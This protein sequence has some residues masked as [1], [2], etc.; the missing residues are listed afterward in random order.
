MNNEPLE[1]M[2]LSDFINRAGD[3]L[4]VPRELRESIFKIESGWEH[5][6]R[7]GQVK[8]SPKGALGVGQLM[9]DTA[10]R[11]GVDPNDPV[12]N[13]Y[14]ALKEQKRLYEKY[15]EAT[16]NTKKAILLA[17][18]AYNAGEGAVDKFGGVPPYEETQNY[19][20][21]VAQSLRGVKSLPSQGYSGT[22]RAFAPATPD[23]QAQIRAG[24]DAANG[25]PS[26]RDFA[27]LTP[28]P[29]QVGAKAGPKRP[30]PWS[31][32]NL[33]TALP[34][35]LERLPA[36]VSTLA[37]SQVR[38]ILDTFGRGGAGIE[39]AVAGMLDFIDSSNASGFAPRL[40]PI[41]RA[42]QEQARTVK[43]LSAEA[44]QQR[45]YSAPTRVARDLGAGAVEFA[46]VMAAT[47]G[48]GAVPTAIAGGLYSGAASR[49]RGESGSEQ[50]KQT[51]LGTVAFGL[52]G[53]PTAS[54]PLQSALARAATK[55]G[56]VGAGTTAAN[57]AAG[58]SPE[59]ALIAGG[60]Q[61][62]L[63]SPEFLGSLKWFRHS[64]LGEVVASPDQA[65][66]PKGRVRVLD[67]QG[68]PHM[69]V[70][71]SRVTNQRAVP[72]R[73][74]EQTQ[75]FFDKQQAQ[76]QAKL[77]AARERLRAAE[78][79]DEYRAAKAEVQRLEGVFE[80]IA[81]QRPNARVP[82]IPVSTISQPRLVKP[83]STKPAPSEVIAPTEP[84]ITPT[85][86][87][88]I[89]PPPVEVSRHVP[90]V[91]TPA[92][93]LPSGREVIPETTLSAMVE[94]D[95]AL[96]V[97]GSKKHYIAEALAESSLRDQV[98]AAIPKGSVLTDANQQ[99]TIRLR[100]PDGSEWEVGLAYDHH[101]EVGWKTIGDKRDGFVVRQATAPPPLAEG[102]KQPSGTR[103]PPQVPLEQPS[104]VA[105]EGLSV[106]DEPRA[107]QL[108]RG[109]LSPDDVLDTPLAREAK[110]ILDEARTI[111]ETPT[112]PAVSDPQIPAP[113]DRQ[114]PSG[115]RPAAQIAGERQ[116][117]KSA[118]AAGLPEATDLTYDVVSDQAA[119]ERA[120]QRIA[121]STPD[122][123]ISEIAG[124]QQLTKDDVAAASILA[125]RLTLAGD[126]E[127]ASRAIDSVLPK[128]TASAQV[129]QGASMISKLSPEG[130]LFHVRRSGAE[131]TAPQAQ[132][133]V[134]KAQDFKVKDQA[135][136]A[137][138]RLENEIKAQQT[139]MRRDA[140]TQ[141]TS[142]ATAK[143][144]IGTL[145]DRLAQ[146]EADARARLKA[147]QEQA[148]KL[149]P[150]AGASIIPLDIADYVIIGASKLA[151]KGINRA[152]W[153]TDMVR[154]F[155][156]D[157]RPH[158]N[159]IFA[160]SFKLKED[161][162]KELLNEQRLRSAAKAAPDA[163]DLQVVVEQRLKAQREAQ[164]AARSL[165]R[166]YEHLTQTKREKVYAGITG[167]RRA[168]L[169]T[170]VKTH[171][172][173]IVS[174]TA[175]QA[176]EEL[177]RPLAVLGD[178]IASQRTGT[179]TTTG[180]DLPAT[181]RAT[182][183]A[184]IKEGPARARDIMLGREVL[185]LEGY[186]GGESIGSKMQLHESNTGIK[187]LDAY[188]NTVFRT[189]E[190]EDAVFKVYAFRRELAD[191]ARAQ[192]INEKAPNVAQ[193]AREIQANP[194]EAQVMEAA[195][196]A[197]YA[198]FQNKNIISTGLGAFKHTV[199]PEG[200]L[201]I[202]TIAPFDRTPTNILA[203][204]LENSPLGLVSAARKYGRIGSRAKA[205]KYASDV[206]K[207]AFT[208]AEQKEFA[209]TF[210]RA[211]TGTILSAL[212][213]IL[214]HKGLLSGDA[215][216]DTNPSDYMK[217]RR[218]FGGGGMLRIPGTSQRVYIGDTPAGKAMITAAGIYEQMLKEQGVDK[219]L[220]GSGRVLLNNLVLDQ[221]LV[222]GIR[223]LG[224]SK[225]V[226][227]AAGTLG[228]SFVPGSAALR[229]G[230]EVIDPQPR[231]VYGQGAV[232]P[233]QALT[234]PPLGRA[235][236]PVDTAIDPDERGD[237]WRRVLRAIDP[238]NTTTE[239]HGP[240]KRTKPRKK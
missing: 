231:V 13:A 32:P 11:L 206:A 195:A 60:T 224:E 14:G 237:L 69:I 225:S 111:T 238:F 223:D 25:A 135:A 40:K 100:A 142:L 17:A 9:P 3:K 72:I 151:Q 5:Y 52:Q 96:N 107:A 133:L 21:G 165:M 76:V 64:D 132:S 171:A 229:A 18:A 176:S 149:G 235:N 163:P 169:L 19:V 71:P 97:S 166:D 184:A 134:A 57:L 173:N 62:L 118:V 75:V 140:G 152:Q 226:G 89:K 196:Y 205:E 156:E 157:I 167:L 188:I 236:L 46:P 128:M 182:Y 28:P 234:P 93:S 228:A 201:G 126:N 103:V 53:I 130:V 65:G 74:A 30:D 137:A 54:I 150:Q 33:I 155:G 199:G 129:V 178:L 158:L 81:Q 175:F 189:M 219:K 34:D 10:R 187:V 164:A 141:V 191:I 177:A 84:A 4:Q 170:A 136:Q 77:Q 116:F 127:G 68:E 212:A 101:G 144:R 200:R 122:R 139:A 115:T 16:G 210:G 41:A 197:D 213:M 159:R 218:E 99:G 138:L 59:E 63:S 105:P 123:V 39:E 143:Q 36:G 42:L 24:I 131:P 92:T 73:T 119:V 179:R 55:V 192:A 113:V 50:L 222:R 78:H 168:N 240:K 204:T 2:S 70:K 220:T 174:N 211:A 216:Y 162:R 185:P 26:S 239:G 230:S 47:G 190:A 181:L 145:A 35:I 207:A 125:H 91:V 147:R 58:A 15:L 8:T 20:A 43:G 95:R 38:L 227:E 12:D 198:T 172:R 56:L 106:P 31:N 203:R 61:A 94:I 193:R 104:Q 114:T 209:R 27:R 117:P 217:K 183:A 214:V 215:D 160:E 110:E 121:E 67:Q 233:V 90:E 45:P 82:D 86:Q 83:P 208:A 22:G 98:G 146:M 7:R 148:T 161:Q 88:A 37:P 23:Q 221:P 44:E 66:V 194:T 87:P 48:L 154:E 102:T 51:A 108:A 80:S 109:E 153:V 49:G 232:A 79:I 186:S 202:E 120:T 85:A 180:P 1:R 124:N 29:L 6:D 112:R